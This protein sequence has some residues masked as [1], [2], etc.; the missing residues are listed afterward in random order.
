MSVIVIRPTVS[1][2]FDLLEGRFSDE[3]ELA[4]QMLEAYLACIAKHGGNGEPIRMLAASWSVAMRDEAARSVTAIATGSGRFTLTKV[5]EAARADTG[6]MDV[7]RIAKA[8]GI[9]RDFADMVHH[10]WSHGVF[11]GA[12]RSPA[13]PYYDVAIDAVRD[14][15]RAC[16]EALTRLDA[17]LFALL[18][19]FGARSGSMMDAI[20]HSRAPKPSSS[21]QDSRAS[22]SASSG[23]CATVLSAS[24]RFPRTLC[25]AASRD[26]VFVCALPFVPPS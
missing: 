9:R 1:T 24:T 8:L 19:A 12:P 23:S 16:N 10:D 6:A 26:C 11:G 2:L 7:V 18:T 4:A 5:L 3:P 13:A 25:A 20:R 14:V 15:D 22:R 17:E 21:P